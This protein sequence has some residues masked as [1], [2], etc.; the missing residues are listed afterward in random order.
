MSLRAFAEVLAERCMNKSHVSAG[1]LSDLERGNRFPSPSMLTAL[2]EALEV[3][4]DTLKSYDHRLP[5][6]DMEEMHSMNPQFGFAFR[7]AIEIIKH[8]NIS[9]QELIDRLQD[10]PISP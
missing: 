5:M 7:K 1:F 9:P 8:Q 10:P 2:A 3:S 6:D 4:E